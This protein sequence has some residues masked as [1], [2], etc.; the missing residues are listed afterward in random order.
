MSHG[1]GR[2]MLLLRWGCV[3]TGVTLLGLFVYVV[4]EGRGTPFLKG[5]ATI[6]G[7]L[8]DI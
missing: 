8:L 2:L 4:G 6:R 3:E 7:V 5:S 1:L